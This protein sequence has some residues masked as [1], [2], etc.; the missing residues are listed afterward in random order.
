MRILGIDPGLSITGYGCVEIGPDCDRASAVV[1]PHPT[2]S[3]RERAVGAEPRLVEAGV[4]RLKSRRSLAFRLGQLHDDLAAVLEELRPQVMAVEK[5]FAAYR[6]PRT[7]I[8]MGHARGVV[9]LAAQVRELEL[10]ELN[11]TEVKKSITGNGHASKQQMQRSI[12]S[13][14]RLLTL[15]EPPDVADAI[16]IALCAARRRSLAMV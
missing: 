5:L 3:R 6:H 8:L 7:A 12:M 10:V 2:L 13:Q 1:P 11:A 15:P 14:C 16:G 4:L 9:L